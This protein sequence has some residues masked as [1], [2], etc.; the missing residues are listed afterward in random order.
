MRN[1][2]VAGLL[3]GAAALLCAP[4]Q[5][6]GVEDANGGLMALNDGTFDKAIER[7]THAIQSG[8]LSG[9]DLEFAY[10]NRGVAFLWNGNFNDALADLK[11]A[12]RMKPD[13]L[14]ALGYYR[15][16]VQHIDHEPPA[17]PMDADNV[18]TSVLGSLLSAIANGPAYK[19]WSAIGP[20]MHKCMAY[21]Y[22]VDPVRMV[23]HAI[24][25]NNPALDK[26]FDACKPI[27]QREYDQAAAQYAPKALSKAAKGK[28]GRKH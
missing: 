1:F 24:D 3:F 22:G 13:D 28:A 2:W 17:P 23:K 14:D 9:D 26:Y 12:T 7:F 11:I 21:S 25:I 19:Q 6:S 27:A 5:A 4:A 20:W 10:Y 8:E 15:L 16:A 18:V